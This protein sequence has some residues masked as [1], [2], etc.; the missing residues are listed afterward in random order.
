MKG[1]PNEQ[2]NC[3]EQQGK[4]FEWAANAD[5]WTGQAKQGGLF[6][7]GS[8]PTKS[9]PQKR[10]TQDYSR[11]KEKNSIWSWWWYTTS[12][13]TTSDWSKEMKL[14]ENPLKTKKVKQ[15]KK[16]M[17]ENKQPS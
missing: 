4:F 6:G 3:S 2:V 10:F 12:S 8:S 11:S 16:L 7:I 9:W 17:K 13:P 14:Q 1:L 5:K 15:P